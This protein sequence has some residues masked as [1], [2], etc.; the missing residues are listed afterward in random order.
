MT[1]RAVKSRALNIVTTAGERDRAPTSR[2]IRDDRRE[3]NRARARASALVR[4]TRPSLVD[5]ALFNFRASRAA[6]HV[7]SRLSSTGRLRI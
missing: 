2:D 3:T 4:E 7:S 1:P 6:R 5:E